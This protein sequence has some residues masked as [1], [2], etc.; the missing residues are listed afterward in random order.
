MACRRYR[1]DMLTTLLARLFRA[2][3]ERRADRIRRRRRFFARLGL[4]DAQEV[5]ELAGRV[6]L[7]SGRTARLREELGA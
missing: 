6:D 3:A 5:R 1:R 2:V 7:L 4:A